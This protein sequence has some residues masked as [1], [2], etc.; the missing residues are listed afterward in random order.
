MATSA[1]RPGSQA[2][3]QPIDF[4]GRAA[5]LVHMLSAYPPSLPN[6]EAANISKPERAALPSLEDGAKLGRARIRDRIS[7]Q[8]LTWFFAFEEYSVFEAWASANRG[9]RVS[10]PLPGVG[11]IVSRACK[12]VDEPAPT[13]VAGLGWRVSAKVEVFGG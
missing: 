3:R 13:Y 12:F 9:K 1:T 5:C 7:K 11:G 4:A 6:P 2:S 8:A 10:I